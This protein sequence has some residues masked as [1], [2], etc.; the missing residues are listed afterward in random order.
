MISSYW[1]QPIHQFSSSS[2]N[3]AIEKIVVF[4]VIDTVCEED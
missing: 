3:N 2:S 4:F 1:I